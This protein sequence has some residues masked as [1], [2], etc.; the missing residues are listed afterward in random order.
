MNE[1][2]NEKNKKEN[3]RFRSINKR[4]CLGAIGLIALINTAFL[5]P[6]LMFELQDNLRCGKI[7]LAEAE[8]MDITSFNTGYDKN[9]YQRLFRFAM[10][11]KEGQQFYVASQEVEDTSEMEAFLKSERG[12]YQETFLVWVENGL[13]P[14]DVLLYP[15]T[16]CKKY[17]IYGN[18]FS[19]GV[20]FILWYVELGNE[21]QTSLKLLIDAETEEFY[22]ICFKE[23][24]DSLIQQEY[25]DNTDDYSLKNH[26]SIGSEYD[27]LNI[28]FELACYY[29]GLEESEIFQIAE[30][31]GYDIYWSGYE[32]YNM[33][34]YNIEAYPEM[35]YIDK[36]IVAIDDEKIQKALE[37]LKWEES[38]DGN[39]LDFMFPYSRDG[40]TEDRDISELRF[41]VE[42]E[43][44]EKLYKDKSVYFK[45]KKIVVGFPEIYKWIPEFSE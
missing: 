34:T 25:V 15:I 22:G 41:R 44:A 4:Y 6:K 39:R 43:W 21:G 16:K 40:K 38:E 26:L 1:T 36:N 32:I 14:D 12:L 17:V 30:E 10:K 35:Q 45:A 5:I 23:S 24:E 19:D 2:T 29:G 28:W 7:V 11:L 37:I 20:N 27:M 9:L 3:R 31:Y 8:E 33:E 42:A 18:D 13:I